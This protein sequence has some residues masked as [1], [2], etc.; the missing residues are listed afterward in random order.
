MAG[1]VYVESAP[2]VR[3]PGMWG[4]GTTPSLSLP[5]SLSLSRSLPL[6]PALNLSR[7]LSAQATDAPPGT[8]AISLS[9]FL[10]H[11]HPLSLAHVCV[12][13]APLVRA[14]GMWGAGA[15]HTRCGK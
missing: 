15:T 7:S 13:S 14:L 8:I 4:A 6:S 5:L 3:A 10:S 1:D 2:L 12:E 11:T 9:R